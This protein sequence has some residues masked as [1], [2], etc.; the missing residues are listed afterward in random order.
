MIV[1]VS[2][3]RVI[4]GSEAEIIKVAN[5]FAAI[6]RQ[7]IGCCMYRFLQDPTSNCEFC[8]VEEWKDLEALEAH[9]HAVHFFA[10]REKSAHMV[11]ER[12]VRRYSAQ[13]ISL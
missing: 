13:E 7:E 11:A 1:V 3:I 9:C 6:T 10:W 12:I 2:S 5:E 8:F 4:P